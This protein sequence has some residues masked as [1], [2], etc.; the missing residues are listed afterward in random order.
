VKAAAAAL[1]ALAVSACDPAYALRGDPPPPERCRDGSGTTRFV[2]EN[3]YRR[4]LEK[5]TVRAAFEGYVAPDFVE[6]KPDVAS[7][8]REGT[9]RFLEGLIAEVPQA[10]WELL[11]V[12]AEGDIAAVHARMTPAPGAPAYAIADFFRVADCRIVEH[13]DVVAGPPQDAPNRVPRF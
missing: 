8:D 11:R 3:F 4:A 12:V 9:I 6:H 10:R 13:W 1:L 7:G 5:K 2:V